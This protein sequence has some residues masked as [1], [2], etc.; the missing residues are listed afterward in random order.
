MEGVS[1]YFSEVSGSG[2]E[3]TLLSQASPSQW[4][5]SQCFQQLSRN[6]AE[7]TAIAEKTQQN[8][9]SRSPR[10]ILSCNCFH[11][12]TGSCNRTED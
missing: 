2:V 5:R 11:V 3:V 9:K 1:R 7:N 6:A 8:P 4:V 12:R 10:E